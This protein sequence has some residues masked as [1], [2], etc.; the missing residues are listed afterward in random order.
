MAA[1][2]NTERE[3]QG[4]VPSLGGNHRR[5]LNA[6]LRRLET[7][8]VHLEEKIALI[9]A[10]PMVLTRVQNT[11]SQGQRE[12]LQGLAQALRQEIAQLAV[13]THLEP[14]TL[15][16]ARTI[17]AEFALLWCDLE[18]VRP[19]KLENYG[20]LSPQAKSWLES[21]ITQLIEFVLAIE[22][23]VKSG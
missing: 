1:F 19:N 13:D 3:E 9:S 17:R 15:D 21:R 10:Q 6:V 8:T 18:E 5:A 16:L 20:A 2:E 11:L 7:A 14:A 12:A 22:K 4:P 23:A